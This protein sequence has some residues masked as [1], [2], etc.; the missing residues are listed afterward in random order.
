MMG[1]IVETV[2][3]ATS[4][5]LQKIE[6]RRA[7]VSV[8]GLGYVG[9][10]LAVAFAEAGFRVTGIDADAARVSSI[11]RGQSY[12]PDVASERLSALTSGGGQ[13]PPEP[14]PE[15]DLRGR[16]MGSADYE[17]LE[18]ADV[19][20]VCVP[21]PLSKTKD[22]DLSLV[23]AVTGEIA[24]RLHAGMLVVLESTTYPG[25]TEEVIL[26]SLEGAEG[27]SF[28]AG[29]DFFLAF[30]PERI[31]PGRKDWTI[32]NTPK[33]MGGA[34]PHCLQVARK[35]YE[36][37]VDEITPVSSPK[38]AEMV[39]LLENT[40]RAANVALVNETA[41]MC[42]R[43]GVDVWEVIDAAKT[44]PFGFMP[45]YPGPGLG[46]HCIPVDPQY[47]AWKMRTLGYNA[48]FIQVADEINLGM[49]VYVLGK[50]SDA[51]NE[52]GKPLKGSK[53][54]V[55][56]VAYKADVGDTRESPALDVIELLLEKGAA[57][58]YHDPYVPE[59]IVNGHHMS[60][61]QL[62]T[63][64]LRESDCVVITTAHSDHDW[65]WVVKSSRLVVDTRNATAKVASTG[66]NV[67]KL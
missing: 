15:S 63:T 4:E 32:R 65:E 59:L 61:V 47:L 24:K 7:A 34:T 67:V 37:V 3:E 58:G 9:L 12:L 57:A 43:L 48:R 31:D 5:L 10:P 8:I 33:V 29:T 27:L 39:K 62:N 1:A 55:L 38:V 2:P 42:D 46:G 28:R 51:L 17:A 54:L 20:I 13:S 11:N 14:S 18:H 64:A 52:R 25:T 23:V 6:T 36:T 40:F 22:P 60:S 30:S 21:T 26:P 16:L 41:I 53:V 66:G 56:G 50:I 35:L 49:P 19:A 45:F 44:K